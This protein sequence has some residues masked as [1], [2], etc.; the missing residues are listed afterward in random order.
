MGHRGCCGVP[1][2]LSAGKNKKAA[3][4]SWRL[5]DKIEKNL[6]LA[7]ELGIELLDPTSGVD[8]AFFAG[9]CRVRVGSDIANDDLVLLAVD[10]FRLTRTHCRA[11]EEL[12]TGR[13]IDKGDVIKLRMNFSFHK[14]IFLIKRSLPLAGFEARV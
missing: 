6:A 9:V 14:K 2:P 5:F 1:F 4:K 8:K 3:R 11:S 13:N 12:A 7:A 10:G